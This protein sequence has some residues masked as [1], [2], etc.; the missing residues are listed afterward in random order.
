[1]T[2]SKRNSVKHELA[3]GEVVEFSTSKGLAYAQS[4]HLDPSRGPLLRV[5]PGFFRIRPE[6]LGP[7][8]D[9]VKSYSFFV[10]SPIEIGPGKPE[11]IGKHPVPVHAQRFP[12]FRNGVRD[13]AKKQS[14]FWWLWDGQR[15]WPAGRELTE[16]QKDLSILHIVPLRRIAMDIEAGWSPR[17]FM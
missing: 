16:E 10:E 13:P 15:E 12:L 7:V 4:T 9:Q 6:D 5:L 11:V 14:T 3:V 8:L 17:D 1:M 2:Q